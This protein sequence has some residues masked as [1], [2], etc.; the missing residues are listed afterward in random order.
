M[1]TALVQS[2]VNSLVS[3]PSNYHRHH[4]GEE[5]EQYKCRLC[6]TIRD[7]SSDFFHCTK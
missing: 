2:V 4:N 7:I 6:G 5:D 3:V 1:V